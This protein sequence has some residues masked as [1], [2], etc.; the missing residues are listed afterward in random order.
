VQVKLGGDLQE[1]VR[2]REITVKDIEEG[3]T[4]T[5]L[6]EIMISRY[7]DAFS[8]IIEEKGRLNFSYLVLING[9]SLESPA[10]KLKN[11]DRVVIYPAI[12]GG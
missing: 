7:G 12:G 2:A 3:T 9:R 6:I 1:A 5:D 8:D 11:G 4:F 10:M